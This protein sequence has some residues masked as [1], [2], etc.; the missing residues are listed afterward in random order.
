[1]AERPLR[2]LLVEDE[3][4]VAMNVE[5]MLLELG[6]EVAGI[7]TRLD[8]ALVLARELAFDAAI[9]DV[10]LAGERSF[11]VADLLAER[12]IPFLFATGYGLQ[13]IEE[14]FRSAVVL[15][16]PFRCADL[17]ETLE[18]LIARPP[19]RPSFPSQPRTRGTH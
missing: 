19:D 5:D 7:A 15:Q 17:G 16:K 8:Q 2:I 1:L 4:L 12:H 6:Y 11:A 9:L 14:R 10:N 13:G 18:Q 3:M